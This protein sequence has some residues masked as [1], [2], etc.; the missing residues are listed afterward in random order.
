MD[1]SNLVEREFPTVTP[2]TRVS[3]LQGMFQETGT[4]AIVVVDDGEYLGIVTLRQMNV[5][6]RD[7]DAKARSILWH[8][9]KVDRDEDVRRVARLILA[10]R[11]EVLP[12]FD[13]EELVGTVSTD[14]V[15]EAVQQFL[16]VLTV[17]DVYSDSLVTVGQD[18][19]FGEA[20]NAF[21]ENGITH[22][23][24][25]EDG[26]VVGVVSLTDI[27]DFTTRAMDK[28]SGGSSGGF[29]VSSGGSSPGFRS[30]GGMGDRAGE[31]E[32]MLDLPVVDVMSAP[33][34]TVLPNDG[35]DDAVEQML[36]DGVSSLIVV[37][38]N[39]PAGIVTKSD[40]LEALTWTGESRLP[41]QITNVE[42]LDDISRDEVVA[43][44]EG[45]ADK[46]GGLTI[47]E[48]NVYL[49][50]HDEKLRGTPL[51]M[52]RIRLF[53]D[54]GHFVGTG[55]GYGASHALHLAR[56]IVERQLLEGKT[57]DE[58]KKPPSDPDE[59]W[60]KVFGWWLTAPPRRR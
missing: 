26:D 15:L 44:V 51:I 5:T 58:T 50:E 37:Q 56:N 29:D 22:L 48:A 18:S 20:L 49:H 8:P 3:K 6:H 21:R 40:V 47:L 32:R 36:D 43:M 54:K 30:A 46:Y 35:L 23:P 11:S 34:A 2:E 25:A 28:P 17:E 59:Y 10:S 24:V 42:L 7:P 27:L 39:A 33:V 60:S 14:R 16:G 53:T 57:H 13:D 38:E 4:K 52:A 55:E 31:L 41:V 9:A 45:F 12:V 1:I 19:T